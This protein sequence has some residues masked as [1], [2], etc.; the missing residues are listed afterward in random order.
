ML[1]RPGGEDYTQLG[2]VIR[3]DINMV[4]TIAEVSLIEIDMSKL[5]ICQKNFAEDS[6]ERG[7]RA[8]PNCMASLGAIFRVFALTEDQV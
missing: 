1:A 5:G 2:N 3:V 4:E 7:S 6:I 8:C